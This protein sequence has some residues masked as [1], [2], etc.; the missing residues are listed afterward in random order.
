MCSEGAMKVLITDSLSTEGVRSLEDAGFYVKMDTSLDG[1]ALK[2][3]IV[4]YDGLIIRSG[5]N[6]TK[7]IIENAGNLKVI[8]R[9]GVGVDN[10]DVE[11]ATRKGIVVM[12]TPSGNTISACEHTW[13]LI[14]STLRNIP[15]SHQA[16]VEGRW[17]KKKYKG[18]EIYGKTLGIIGLGKIGIEVAKRAIGFGMKIIVY[19]PYTSQDIAKEAKAKLVELNE[20][21]EASDVITIHVP[22]NEKTKN[23]I[24]SSALSKMKKE[25]IL[26]NCARGGIVNEAALSEAV[27]NR[28]IRGAAVDVYETEPTTDSPVFSVDGI[29]HTPH[30][31]ASTT[32]AVER[33]SIE[34]VKQAIDYLKD[35]KIINAVNIS[36][37][38]LE[39]PLE[40]LASKLGMLLG[41]LSKHLTGRILISYKE[42]KSEDAIIRTILNGYLSQF[43]EGINFINA[44]L[45]AE[46][47]GIEI[48]KQ[49][50]THEGLPWD[51]NITLGDDLNISGSV[52]GDITRLTGIN[53]YILDIPLIGNL[54]IIK[55]FDIPGVIGHIGT[56]LGEYGINI[57][58]MEVGRKS[59]GGQAVTVIG[60]DQEIS[61]E[62][63]EKLKSLKTIEDVN[64]VRVD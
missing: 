17:D 38:E 20:L 53:G 46:E 37:A 14:L 26:I 57:G 61:Q 31:G 13:A 22:L 63:I 10:V 49:K 33:V 8:G 12:N 21:L 62:I 52:I 47:K 42:E 25:A 35:G 24:D 41:Q 1:E 50:V 28:Q 64:S 7:D 51:I 43:N 60:V 19:D 45:V 32:E 27:K 59:A 11:A 5:T 4:N 48:V 15:Q 2:K 44:I 6:V 56:I 40:K 9:A 23:L 3:E 29:I 55:N 18:A 30:L 58:S 39:L 16:L 54:L 34:I 36:G